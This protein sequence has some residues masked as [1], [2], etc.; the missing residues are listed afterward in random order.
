VYELAKTYG[1]FYTEVSILGEP[2]ESV[3]SFRVALSH[4]TAQTIGHGM[5]LL[6]IQVPERM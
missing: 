4:L 6:G 5:G 3:R 2:D 1:R